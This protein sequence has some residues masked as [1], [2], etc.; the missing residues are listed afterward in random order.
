MPLCAQIEHTA[1]EL[2]E[3]G[4]NADRAN[5]TVPK[6]QTAKDFM[7]AATLFEVCK[8]FGDLPDDL[9]EKVKYGKWRYVEI[10]KAAKEK[11]APVP[12]PA[13]DHGNEGGAAAEPS[14]ERGGAVVA[15]GG[16]ASYLDLPAPSAE[17]APA[18][19]PPAPPAAAPSVPPMQPPPA[20]PAPS[21]PSLANPPV[22]PQTP[23]GLPHVSSPRGQA[24][25]PGFK[26]DT[27]ASPLGLILS[28]SPTPRAAHTT[29]NHHEQH[30][31]PCLV[32]SS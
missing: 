17:P 5:P 18:P 19:A 8:E 26:P 32:F 21:A 22:M 6:L 14:S 11:R 24:P 7:A 31:P 16:G 20:Y 10:C 28:H 1:M 2:F 23:V 12:P 15:D 29:S 4:D 9:A 13:V 3:R 30:S 27:C 25:V